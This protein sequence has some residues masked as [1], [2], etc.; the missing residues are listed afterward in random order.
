MEELRREEQYIE[1]ALLDEEWGKKDKLLKVEDTGGSFEEKKE[2]LP[3][4][5]KVK[6]E[7]QKKKDLFTN[8]RKKTKNI[9]FQNRSPNEMKKLESQLGVGD[10]EKEDESEINEKTKN[11]HGSKKEKSDEKIDIGKNEIKE[12]FE[13]KNILNKKLTK[14]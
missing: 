6:N 5:K 1:N 14:K 13:Y 7:K 10:T 8:M 11:F 3:K 9:I 4:I 2:I 12:N